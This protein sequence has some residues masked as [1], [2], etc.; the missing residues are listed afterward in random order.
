MLLAA[1]QTIR[2]RFLQLPHGAQP[3]LECLGILEL[4]DLLELV[5]AYHDIT[6]FLLRYLF[7]ELQDFINIVAL[8][9]HFERYGKVRHRIGSYRDFGS[10]ARK[11]QS[12]IFQPFVQLGGGLFENGGSKGIVKIPVAAA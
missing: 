4:G 6:V 1:E 12:G 10:Y 9:V 2:H 8:G 11:E 7:G 3:L 5:D